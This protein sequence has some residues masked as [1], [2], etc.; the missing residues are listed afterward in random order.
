MSADSCRLGYR[1]DIEGLRA[2]AILLVV[3]AHA[4][5][6]WLAGGYV[7][8]DVF[9][10]LSGFLIT[11]LLLQEIKATGQVGFADFYLRRLRRLM[12]AFVV[13]I[14]VTS[15]V[16]AVVLP[17]SEQPQQA[18]TA[19]MAA[20][21]LSNI[22]FALS[23]LDYF[24]AGADTNLFLHTWSLGVEEQFYLL[25]PALLLWTLG[26]GQGFGRIAR[27]RGVMGGVAVLS[28]VACLVFTHR[29][30]Q[31]AFYMMPMRAWEFALGALVWL[32]FQQKTS[33]VGS[34]VASDRSAVIRCWVGWFGLLLVVSVGLAFN[35]DM[36]YPGWRALLPALG[37]VAIV[38]A[39]SGGASGGVSTLL[40]SQQLQA[41]GRVSYSLYLWHWP[42]LLLGQSITGSHSPWVRATEVLISFGLAVLSYRYVE[43]PIRHQTYWLNRQRMTLFGLVAAVALINLLSV[44]WFATARERMQDPEL[45]RYLKARADLPT[46]YAKGCD[47]YYHS[48]KV[49]LCTFGPE[50]AAH[51]AV[52]MGDSIAAQWFPALARIFDRPNWR[53]IV[54]TKS[55]CPMVD[56]TFFYARI[57]REYTECSTW[58]SHALEQVASIKPDMVVLGTVASDEFSQEQWVDGSARVLNVI[59]AASGHIYVMRGTPRLPF[60]GPDCLSGHKEQSVRS[61]SLPVCDAPAFEKREQQV[62][63]WLQLASAQFSNVRTIDMN[64]LVCPQGHCRAELNGKVV[65]RDSQHLTASFARSLEPELRRRMGL[66]DIAATQ[67]GSGPMATH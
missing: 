9:F 7:G 32:Y 20:L 28:F 16:A 13:M 57:R 65:F 14:V 17:P 51:T 24:A 41:L 46:I 39:G 31:L 48:D 10:V 23:Q 66:S 2:V 67:V 37:A 19:G 60:D 59:S 62:Y 12:P 54:L 1:G 25:W 36:P 38:A 27:L 63:R 22:H 4:G 40:A 44:Q 35:T 64:D 61:G 42:V 11:G 29:S 3:A 56:V 49:R 53:L 55:S 50:D 34:L 30:P 26:G 5:V 47:D 52:L 8:V 18:E 43:S 21:W 33:M 6:P 15:L 58:R 45:Q